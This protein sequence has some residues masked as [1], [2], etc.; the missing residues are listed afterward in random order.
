MFSPS[1]PIIGS[2]KS[3]EVG[4]TNIRPAFAGVVVTMVGSTRSTVKLTVAVVLF[5][6]RSFALSVTV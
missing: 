3:T 2:L 4:P 1:P 5:P 6:A